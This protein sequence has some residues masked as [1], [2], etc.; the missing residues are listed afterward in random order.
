MAGISRRTL[1]YYESGERTPSA[2]TLLKLCELYSISVEKM[3]SSD[4]GISEEAE[5]PKRESGL[6]EKIDEYLEYERTKKK[7]VYKCVLIF[8]AALSV[9]VLL[10]L[11]VMCI[12]RFHLSSVY[13]YTFSEA[14]AVLW[15]GLF[16]TLIEFVNN[17]SVQRVPVV[18]IVVAS[19]IVLAWG[20]FFLIRYI[21]RKK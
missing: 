2:E 10:F 14:T 11:A 6:Q 17:E 3:I 4:M 9:A 15:T 5:E 18:S 21:R 1:S 12:L 20:A 13:G 16:E 7:T 19:V 8:L